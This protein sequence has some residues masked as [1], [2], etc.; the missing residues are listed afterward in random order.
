MNEKVLDWTSKGKVISN[1]IKELQ[2]FSDQDIKVEI[3]LDGGKTS[4]PISLVGKVDGKCLLMFI[5]E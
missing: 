1:L 5:G 2:S 4:K 3:S